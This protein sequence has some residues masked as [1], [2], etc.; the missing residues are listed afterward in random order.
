MVTFANRK[1]LRMMPW[2]VVVTQL[3]AASSL[4]ECDVVCGVGN[5]MGRADTLV[6]RL[7]RGSQL[8]WPRLGDAS[9]HLTAASDHSYEFL[10]CMVDCRRRKRCCDGA[11]VVTRLRRRA[12]TIIGPQ[13][14]QHHGLVKHAAARVAACRLGFQCQC[15]GM[16]GGGVSWYLRRRRGDPG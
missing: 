15:H 12:G 8:H 3:A 9:E 11:R 2:R 14:A 6:K 13:A 1:P 5:Q 4:R 7:R 16:S 10:D